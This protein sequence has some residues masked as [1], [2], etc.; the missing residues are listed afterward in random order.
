M[1]ALPSAERIAETFEVLEDWEQRYRYIIE[2]GRKLP[3]LGPEARVEENRVAGC[4]SQVWLVMFAEDGAPERLHFIA[5]SDAHIVRGLIAILRAAY[6]GKTGNEIIDFDAEELMRTLGL[7]EHL[8]PNRRNGLVS[9]IGRI[10]SEAAN[11]AG[12]DA[13]ETTGKPSGAAATVH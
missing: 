4:V 6:D 2:L 7:D 13:T 1:A 11:L 5:D 3:P 9:M 8:S 10:K 12:L